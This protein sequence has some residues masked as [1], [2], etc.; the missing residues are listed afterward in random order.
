MRRDGLAHADGQ[1]TGDFT[2]G[3]TGAFDPV[4]PAVWEPEAIPTRQSKHASRQI[5]EIEESFPSF[6]TG[7]G[8]GEGDSVMSLQGLNN[9]ANSVGRGRDEENMP[10]IALPRPIPSTRQTRSAVPDL[11]AG[12]K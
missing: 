4:L 9:R 2:A 11:P 3:G 8:W 12:L 5:S 10:G 1:Q 6:D 7:E